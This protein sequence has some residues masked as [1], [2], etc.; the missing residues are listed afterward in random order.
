MLDGDGRC[1][2]RWRRH[3]GRSAWR[4][5]ACRRGSRRCRSSPTTELDAGDVLDADDRAVVVPADDDLLELG[6]LVESR[7]LMVIGYSKA[8][9]LGTGWAPTLPAAAW[10]F[11]CWIAVMTS[12]GRDQHAR[13]AVGV[14]PDPHGVL[15]ADHV[16]VADPLDPLQDVGDVD[17][18]VVVEEVGVVLAR[19]ARSG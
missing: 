15:P 12:V 3:T 18:A 14:E 13:Q 10:T 5:R 9:P 8:W 7:P 6:C 4:Q 19:R 1:P 2:E 16:D 11:S 17:L